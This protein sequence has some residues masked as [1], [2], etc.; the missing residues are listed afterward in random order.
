MIVKASKMKTDEKCPLQFVTGL[1]SISALACSVTAE[2]EI[3]C[4]RSYG[5]LCGSIPALS[6]NSPAQSSEILVQHPG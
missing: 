3:R 4:K 6:D 1:N 2:L 5:Y